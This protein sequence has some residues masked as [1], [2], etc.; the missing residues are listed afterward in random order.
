MIKRLSSLNGF[1]CGI[2]FHRIHKNGDKPKGQGSISDK[3]LRNLIIKLDPLNF[4]TPAEW[5]NINNEQNHKSNKLC[6][7]FD[8]GLKCQHE[9]ALPILEEFNIKGFWFIFTKTFSGFYDRNEIANYLIT[10]EYENIKNFL[11]I[12]QKVSGLSDEKLLQNKKFKFYL[13]RFKILYPFYSEEDIK[14]RYLRNNL[15]NSSEFNN[16]IDEISLS[17][18]INLDK[19][20]LNLWMNE[21]DLRFLSENGHEIGLHSHNHPFQISLLN[22]KEQ[23]TEYKTN[24]NFLKKIT[25]K[26]PKSMSH[27]LN[28]Y[29]KSTFKV[30][31]ELQIKCGFSAIVEKSDNI[32]HNNKNLIFSR[33]DASLL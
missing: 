11:P 25:G 32:E 24:F 7:T 28:S 2:M 8:D 13:S 3:D 20:A 10:Y 14:Y 16:V 26:K 17:K 18:N 9:I 4:L 15:L 6:I 5:Y 19:L 1:P 21:K 22:A 27:P 30:L 29:N 33:L 23:F 31:N 12:F